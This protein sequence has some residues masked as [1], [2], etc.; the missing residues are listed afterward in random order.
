MASTFSSSNDMETVS[1]APSS[2][3]VDTLPITTSPSIDHSE[4]TNPTNANDSVLHTEEAKQVPSLET[5]EKCTKSSGGEFEAC[6]KIVKEMLERREATTSDS[7][8]VHSQEADQ[9]SLGDSRAEVD[10][11]VHKRNSDPS[12]KEERENMEGEEKT[13]DDETT[14]LANTTPRKKKQ[15]RARN[16]QT[17]QPLDEEEGE[18]GC[19]GEKGLAQKKRGRPR[20]TKEGEVYSPPCRRKNP[21]I[22]RLPGSRLKICSHCG[23]V[24]D[25]VK[26]KKCPK[27][28]KFFFSHWAQRCKIP[29]CPNCHFSRKS[30]R[31]E[32]FPSNCEKCGFKLPYDMPEQQSAGTNVEEGDGME[33]VESGSTSAR[34]TPD[35][36]ELDSIPCEWSEGKPDEGFDNAEDE[37]VEMEEET[38]EKKSGKG[39]GR[40]RSRT[41]TAGTPEKASGAQPPSVKSIGM[42][43]TTMATTRSGRAYKQSTSPEQIYSGKATEVNV[44]AK[45]AQKISLPGGTAA[46]Q[47]VQREPFQLPS[48]T[49]S[50]KDQVTSTSETLKEVLNT[51][52]DTQSPAVQKTTTDTKHSSPLEHTPPM[53]KPPSASV[54]EGTFNTSLS[55]SV[56]IAEQVSSTTSTEVTEQYP[57]KIS[58]S[59]LVGEAEQSAPK[60]LPF[61]SMEV[62]EQSYSLST[63]VQA[64]EQVP[65]RTLLSTLMLPAEQSVSERPLST[66]VQEGERGESKE[67]VSGNLVDS[68]MKETADNMQPLSSAPQP[69]PPL[70]VPRPHSPIAE[71][72]ALS[73]ATEPQRTQVKVAQHI[74]PEP[75]LFP[76]ATAP[77]AEPSA[78]PLEAEP[79]LPLSP[80]PEGQQKNQTQE[81]EMAEQ[82]A[83]ETSTLVDQEVQVAPRGTLSDDQYP[84]VSKKLSPPVVGECNTED[85]VKGAGV[86]MD[87]ST[88]SA[89]AVVVSADQ[90][91][92][93]PDNSSPSEQLS[94]DVDSAHPTVS[95][96]PASL[97]TL[98]SGVQ[99]ER[100]LDR[101]DEKKEKG[102]GDEGG[103]LGVYSNINRSLPFL[104]SVLS[105]VQGVAEQGDLMGAL[106]ASASSFKDVAT[107]TSTTTSS[108]SHSLPVLYTNNLGLEDPNK[109][110]LK[111]HTQA[112]PSAEDGSLS[113]STSVNIQTSST[114]EVTAITTKIPGS[115]TI[116]SAMAPPCEDMVVTESGTLINTDKPFPT[117]ADPKATE[118][119]SPAAQKPGKGKGA[120]GKD[121]KPLTSRKR[122]QP[123]T[124]EKKEETKQV[125]PRKPRTKKS[126]AMTAAAPTVTE[127]QSTTAISM[128]ATSIAQELQRKPSLSSP[129]VL[130]QHPKHSFSQYFYTEDG[131]FAS[132]MSLG[133]AG[134]SGSGFAEGP[135]TSSKRSPSKVKES[136]EPPPKKKKLAAIA[137]NNPLTSTA[138][139]PAAAQLPLKIPQLY[140][141]LT[142]RLSPSSIL[143]LLQSVLSTQNPSTAGGSVGNS[144]SEASLV[145]CSSSSSAPPNP[146]PTS[147][148]PP[149]TMSFQPLAALLSNMPMATA[150][151]RLSGTQ[152]TARPLL[153]S[154]MT[155]SAAQPLSTTAVLPTTTTG[156]PLSLP[157][158]FPSLG[159]TGSVSGEQL[160]AQSSEAS[161][162]TQTAV[163]MDTLKS[164][165]PAI[166]SSLSPQLLTLPNPPQLTSGP[167]A[168]LPPPAP[169]P[170]LVPRDLK[171]FFQ[172]VLM[173]QQPSPQP[174]PL[175]STPELSLTATSALTAAVPLPVIQSNIIATTSSSSSSSSPS[176]SFM[177]PPITSVSMFPSPFLPAPHSSI[178]SFPNKRSSATPPRIPP[179]EVDSGVQPL[180][181]SALPEPSSSTSTLSQPLNTLLPPPPHLL[182]QPPFLPF[183]S[184]PSSPN[185]LSSR[186]IDPV[187]APLPSSSSSDSLLATSH[188]HTAPL[189]PSL[190]R[191]GVSSV[192]VPDVNSVSSAL[193][194]LGHQQVIYT[195]S[196]TSP[197]VCPGLQPASSTSSV[198][199]NLQVPQ[200]YNMQT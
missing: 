138:S 62:A 90:V 8:Q 51:D 59:S 45:R 188:H 112:V 64:A 194:P 6:T 24:A 7:G 165:M 5:S 121:G 136:Q 129:V 82:S 196:I 35:P 39:K 135:K 46:G 139:T 65:S 58:P 151:I 168:L 192:A 20:K 155:A 63:S 180:S 99:T 124:Q 107:S 111:P 29:P 160:L 104:R 132:S 154:T 76:P 110:Q 106:S 54:Q 137:P 87:S 84:T 2:M 40:R 163:K 12:V 16:K 88:A 100:S 173:S 30:R 195:Q 178:L 72:R 143:S 57:S 175:T 78:A 4:D 11:S 31:F 141:Q 10:E 42:E 41:D 17:K 171:P 198:D 61:T 71:L 118:K 18:V 97:F 161:V 36:S 134:A 146:L 179:S 144:T 55:I 119:S 159:P 52:P 191:P 131:K 142:S 130:G 70:T 152:V 81:V 33:S 92:R 3:D 60:I 56:E 96:S 9:N 148:F 167:T 177:T 172:S 123:K 37:E 116:S 28:K 50:L 103:K 66:S 68:Q 93:E 122:K 156:L 184:T 109:S 49:P 185:T 145:G 94:I 199:T 80:P 158:V 170:S 75:Q 125:K 91:Q 140:N 187:D 102:E 200:T 157:T 190:L 182:P 25:K 44:T 79:M 1:S 14:E 43:G 67:S 115:E 126:K 181:V 13:R 21:H 23:T 117:T 53:A 101:E 189:I 108:G 83:S 197:K 26:A 89:S 150:P 105:H 128:L 176:S 174:P 47:V 193:P 32:R 162:G 86:E 98:S 113:S 114:T 95:H 153:P 38:E 127:E 85:A 186:A 166:S 19:E 27:C 74:S 133:P 164:L 77:A 15:G 73:S 69:L 147:F 22:A 34:V 48:T 149:L 120:V 183:S 169:P